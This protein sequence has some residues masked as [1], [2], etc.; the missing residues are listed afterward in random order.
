MTIKLR[1]AVDGPRS[2]HHQG[3]QLYRRLQKH[4]IVFKESQLTLLIP[5]DRTNARP[6]D[7]YV[8]HI[9]L[10]VVLFHHAAHTS[11][12]HFHPEAGSF[13]SPRFEARRLRRCPPATFN[14]SGLKAGG[15]IKLSSSSI[16]PRSSSMAI[17]VMRVM[18]PFPD[19]ARFT[20]LK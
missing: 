15:G 19:S 16:R 12:P 14:C 20:V 1:K 17:K 3:R 9:N 18:L 2:R 6:P 10:G 7:K 11:S 13:T 5:G 8:G 4:R